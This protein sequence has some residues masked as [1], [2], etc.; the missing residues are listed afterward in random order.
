MAKAKRKYNDTF[1]DYGFTF[2]ERGDEQLPQCVICFKTLSNA[3]M[4]AYQLKQHLSNTH[5]QFTKHKSL[6]EMKASSLKNEIGQCRTI[7]DS[8]KSDSDCILHSFPS[9]G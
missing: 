5:P 9:S 6:F 4:K 1:F 2:I 8:F 3:S 7:S